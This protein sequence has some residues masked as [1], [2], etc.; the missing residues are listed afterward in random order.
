M[1]DRP[2]R[3][4]GPQ[5]QEATI[6]RFYYVTHGSLRGHLAVFL[7]AYNFAKHLKSLGGLTPFERICP[8]WTEQ[9]GKFRLDPITWRD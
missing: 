5:R 2:D 3:T 8:L 1:D 7:D 9:P 4:D 6:L